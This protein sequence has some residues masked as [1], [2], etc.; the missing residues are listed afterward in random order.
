MRSIETSWSICGLSTHITLFEWMGIREK[1]WDQRFSWIG[2]L[3]NLFGCVQEELSGP[4][5]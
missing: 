1:L 5:F 4:F 2:G 3:V